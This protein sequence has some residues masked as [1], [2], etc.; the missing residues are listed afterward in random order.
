MCYLG[1]GIKQPKHN[2]LP[3]KFLGIG[4]N[5]GDSLCYFIRTNPS[6]KSKKPQTLVR[7]VVRKSA[8]V[9]NMSSN[10]PDSDKIMLH[11]EKDLPPT[12]ILKE[13]F[14][15]H[16]NLDPDD[17]SVNAATTVASSDVESDLEDIDV[18]IISNDDIEEETLPM[19]M[20]DS[21]HGEIEGMTTTTSVENGESDN[22]MNMGPFPEVFQSIMND[23]DLEGF[24]LNQ[25]INYSHEKGFLMLSCELKS[26]EILPVPF[27]QLKRI[28][29]MK[30]RNV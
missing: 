10:N 2:I 3:G 11:V 9:D 17:A 23:V 21:E 8:E 19:N 16:A 15:S 29:L 28:I 12:S 13:I 26:G 14:K 18:N 27:D 20:T 5:H 6:D 25:I 7:S 24:D 4:W 22:A 30:R 1:P